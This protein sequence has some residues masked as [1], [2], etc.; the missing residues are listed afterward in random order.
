MQ[1]LLEKYAKL[2][3]HYCLEL[4]AEEKL[5]VS[6]TTLAEPL[7]REIYREACTLGVVMETEFKFSEQAGIFLKNA[8]DTLI[9]TEPPFYKY[10]MEHFDAYLHI[11]APFNLNET[12][13][14]DPQKRK[15]R[16]AAMKGINAIYFDRTARRDEP[17]GLKRSLCQFPT[18]A[19]A[20]KA[21]MS[22]EEYTHF[23]FNACHLYSEDPQSEWLK[24]R[25]K[26]E[27]IKQYLDKVKQIRYKA[28]HTDISFSVE[29]R[30]WINSDG[31]SNMPSGEVFSAPVEDSVN[32][33]VHFT[34]PSIYMGQD[35][36]GITLWVEEGKIVEWKAEQGQDLLDHVFYIP[37]ANYFGEVAIGTNYQ[38]QQS[39]RNILFDEKIGGTIH[40]AVGQSYKQCGGKNQSSIHWDMIT[41]MTQSGE[42]YADDKLIYEKGKFLI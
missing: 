35:V 24:I 30:S 8:P 14:L 5:F 40:M 25:K 23:V 20:Q 1:S 39:T 36:R 37:G 27:V 31:R 19:A 29:G 38:I 7:V 33:K 6:M 21:N 10:A 13:R 17:G 41:D 9:Q 12:S 32:G 4:K 26:Q 2:L 11:R 18:Q 42:I 22:L 28:D 15:Q 34:F 3:V 16:S